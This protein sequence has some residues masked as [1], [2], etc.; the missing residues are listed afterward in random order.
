MCKHI[1]I[2]IRLYVPIYIWVWR[3]FSRGKESN[4]VPLGQFEGFH[5]LKT[6]YIPFRYSLDRAI[7][8]SQEG[9]SFRHYVRAY[10][11]DLRFFVSSV[12]L[13]RAFLPLSTFLSHTAENNLFNFRLQ[14]LLFVVYFGQIKNT[15]ST[16][17]VTGEEYIRIL[18]VVRKLGSSRDR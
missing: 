4:I 8:S 17:A 14:S 1:Y 3:F 15:C 13:R 11:D 2:D 12:H 10:V 18:A 16:F 6:I 5:E 7:V 9:L